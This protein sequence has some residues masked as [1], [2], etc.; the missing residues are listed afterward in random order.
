[1]EGGREGGSFI[2]IVALIV[3]EGPGRRVSHSASQ[4]GRTRRTDGADYVAASLARFAPAARD[5]T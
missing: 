3:T 1:M 5:I 4:Q 2:R